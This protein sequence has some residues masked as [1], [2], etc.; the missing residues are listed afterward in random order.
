MNILYNESVFSDKSHSDVK[1]SSSSRPS[2]ETDRSWKKNDNAQE[3]KST[4]SS[5]TS[6][7]NAEANEESFAT[8]SEGTDSDDNSQ[9][10]K[11]KQTFS[12]TKRQSAVVVAKPPRRNY[13]STSK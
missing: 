5:P 9:S 6:V 2:N 13:R 12:G 10:A 11:N 4:V 1:S 8:A 3:N 7:Q